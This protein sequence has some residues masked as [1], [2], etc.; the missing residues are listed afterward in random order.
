MKMNEEN[1]SDYLDDE[2][3]DYGRNTKTMYDR[4]TDADL[5][6]TMFCITCKKI[7]PSSNPHVSIFNDLD[8]YYDGPEAEKRMKEHKQEFPDHEGFLNLLAIP[9][10]PKR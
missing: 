3:F 1:F 5:P 10:V 8:I 4:L 7:F 2:T 9:E 6:L